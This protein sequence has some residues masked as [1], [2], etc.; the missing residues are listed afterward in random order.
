MCI[1]FNNNVS[2]II[3]NWFLKAASD[4]CI[5]INLKVILLNRQFCKIENF[6]FY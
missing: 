3:I 4:Y 6:V 5:N 1:H 2:N